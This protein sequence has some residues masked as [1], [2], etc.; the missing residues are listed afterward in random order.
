MWTDHNNVVAINVNCFPLNSRL[1]ELIHSIPQKKDVET[2][3]AREEKLKQTRHF[4]PPQGESIQTWSRFRSFSREPEQD[5]R[6]AGD[7]WQF[8][9]PPLPHVHTL[10]AAALVQLYG[11]SSINKGVCRVEC[12]IQ[13]TLRQC[14]YLFILL[15]IIYVYIA[16]NTLGA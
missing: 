16:T 4:F 11:H 8:S 9:P 3:I 5:R 10:I 14:S 6:V 1:T 13:C 15:L 12:Y 2:R 7:S